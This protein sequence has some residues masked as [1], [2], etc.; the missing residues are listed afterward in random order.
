MNDPTQGFSTRELIQ[1]RA[2][3]SKQ[4]PETTT[5]EINIARTYRRFYTAYQLRDL[6]NEVPIHVV[7]RRYEVPRGLVQTL[8]QTCEGF[9]AGMIL[10]CERMGWGMLRAALEHMSDRLKAGAK[11]DLLDLAKIPFVK[12]QTARVFWEHGM[13]S[14]S[15]VAEAD[16]K[17]VV[18]V[19]L[20]VSWYSGRGP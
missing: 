12:S 5:E 9:A 18:P 11:D 2:N 16:P 8:A 4:L 20:V 14:L 10:F 3:S 17:D 6:C 15:L 1:D 19:L 13:K 7:A